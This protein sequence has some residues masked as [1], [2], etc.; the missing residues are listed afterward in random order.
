[1]AL[2]PNL[3]EGKAVPVGAYIYEDSGRLRL[4]CCVTQQ[5]AIISVWCFVPALDMI[6]I[7]ACTSLATQFQIA[8]QFLKEV[9][10]DH[11]N[12]IRDLRKFVEHHTFLFGYVTRLKCMKE[13]DF[14]F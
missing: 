13:I 3:F 11:Y 5:I 1:M 14:Y 8:A 9:K 2:S 10:H 6:Y 4:I 7:G 12:N